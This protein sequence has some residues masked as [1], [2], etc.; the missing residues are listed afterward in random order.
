MPICLSL[1]QTKP[2]HHQNTLHHQ[3][4]AFQVMTSCPK[5]EEYGLQRKMLGLGKLVSHLQWIIKC[6]QRHCPSSKLSQG[7]GAHHPTYGLHAQMKVQGTLCLHVQTFTCQGPA[8]TNKYALQGS[9]SHN[10]M[11]SKPYLIKEPPKHV[12][13][14]PPFQ[15]KQMLK[16]LIQFAKFRYGRGVIMPY[17]VNQ[18]LK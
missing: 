1:H 18:F 16:D 15:N 14:I 10:I 12:H 4:L 3:T 8:K 11:L 7:E 13:Q 17:W 9:T 5:R 6:L 2:H